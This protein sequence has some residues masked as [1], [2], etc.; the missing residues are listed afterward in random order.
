MRRLLVVCMMALCLSSAHGAVKVL[1]KKIT[2][3]PSVC[4]TDNVT[5][6]W[7]LEAED[8]TTGDF[9]TSG[10]D[11]V[12]AGAGTAIDTSPP[13][14][15]LGS[16]ALV[17]PTGNGRY[18]SIP[19]TADD[20]VSDLTGRIGMWF[21][22]AGSWPTSG[23]RIFT[24]YGDPDGQIRVDTLTNT[25]ELTVTYRGDDGG[26][27]EN[28]I[29]ATAG[30][31]ITIDTWHY[32]E[33]A[34]DQTLGLDSDILRLYVDGTIVAAASG[35]GTDGNLAAWPVASASNIYLGDYLSAIP[36]PGATYY[37][38]VI[39]SSDPATSLYPCRTEESYP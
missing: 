26:G 30:S 11:V 4:D 6:W 15:P 34:W 17:V 24:I 13:A 32:I 22:F 2:T 1:G 23:R 29:A 21:R 37:D 38:Q 3:A 16:N 27:A 36:W 5:A 12:L 7:R 9:P 20:L 28:T 19:V 35:T 33:V 18:A 25:G 39:V 8:F 10:V 31:V 14:I